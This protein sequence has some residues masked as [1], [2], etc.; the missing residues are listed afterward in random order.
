MEWGRLNLKRDWNEIATEYITSDC[1]LPQLCK[2]YGIP[3]STMLK[4]AAKG[5]WVD[6]RRGAAVSVVDEATERYKEEMSQV[7]DAEFTITQRLTEL[8]KKAAAEQLEIQTLDEDGLPV[9]RVDLAAVTAAAR[10]LKMIEEVKN[11]LMKATTAQEDRIFVLNAE[12]LEIERE[13][14][15]RDTDDE[16]EGGGV[17]FLPEVEKAEN[18]DEQ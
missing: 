11:S 5:K 10:A 2:K 6:R 18:D 9:T 1:N 13:R 15:K 4:Q 12:R 16:D 17:L 3:Y 8:L 14:L 7:I